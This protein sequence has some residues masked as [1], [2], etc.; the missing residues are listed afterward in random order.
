LIGAG[1][2]IKFVPLIL[3]AAFF[4]FVRRRPRQAAALVGA[5]V[6]VPLLLFA[7]FLLADAEGV[8]RA[9]GYSGSPGAGGL[10]MLLQPEIVSYRLSGDLGNV[11]FNG[12][13][14]FFYEHGG[15]I[16]LLALAGTS[17]LL[18]RRRP[19]PVLGALLLIVT[20]Y[21]FAP[22]N[23]L[24]YV[25][26]CVPFLVMAGMLRAAALISAWMLIPCAIAYW[27]ADPALAPLYVA[28]MAVLYA[29]WLVLGLALLRR[30]SPSSDPAPGRAT[31]QAT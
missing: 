16:A 29:G 14:Q 21:V 24:H 4:P 1:A 2:A 20:M 6:A 7:P 15:Q 25:V 12:S 9:V 28:S 22:N 26:W 31:I 8:R 13:S 18:L 11:V 19:E 30:V 27:I 5:A 10:S 17:L 3:L 23:Y